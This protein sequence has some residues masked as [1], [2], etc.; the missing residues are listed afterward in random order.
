L[1][2]A[3]RRCFECVSRKPRRFLERIRARSRECG[4]PGDAVVVAG[5]STVPHRESISHREDARKK[6]RRSR[7]QDEEAA[8]EIADEDVSRDTREEERERRKRERQERR[9]KVTTE[10]ERQERRRKVT[11]AEERRERRERRKRK[12]RVTH[13][14][15]DVR[16]VA[17]DDDLVVE[18]RAIPAGPPSIADF[19]KSCCY[20]CAQN[21]LA[22]AAATA[23]TKPEQSDKGVQVSAHKFHAETY[24]TLD[25]SCSPMQLLVRTVRSS[26]KVRTREIGTLYP[27]ASALPRGDAGPRAKKR[28]KFTMF[29][30]LTR[31]KCPAGR[32]AACGT[33]KSAARRDDNAEKREPRNEKCCRE[34]NA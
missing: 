25:R 19:A 18:D 28:K 27:G 14:A 17:R 30:G 4:K 7:K 11:T 20:L 33:D 26:I 10:E 12:E 16:P 23:V 9:R 13:L 3:K 34:K 15:E 6:F 2:R 31:T 8:V 1:C 21:A 32:H 5:V 29:S 24:P 22:I